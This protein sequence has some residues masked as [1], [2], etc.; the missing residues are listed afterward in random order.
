MPDEPQGEIMSTGESTDVVLV[1]PQTVVPSPPDSMSAEDVEETRRHVAALVGGVRDATGGRRLAVL[2]EVASVGLESQRNAGRQ[3]ELVKTR[4]AT[5]FDAGGGSRDVASD[6]VELRTALDRINPDFERRS[7]WGRTIGALPFMRDNAMIRALRRIAVRY[8]PVSKQIVVIEAKL[9]EGRALLARDNV[10]LRRLYEDVEAQQEAILRQAY[11]GEL[12][13]RE[14]EVLLASTDDQPQRERIQDARHDVLTRVQD[15]R[16]M[17]EVHLQF[18][19]S[20]ELTRQNNTRLGQA[21][22]RTLTMATNIVTVGLAIQAALARQQQVKEAAQRTREFLGEMITQ[23]AAAIRQQTDA[24][25]DLYNDPVIALDK[26]AQA[27]HDLLAALDA[28]SRLRD[29]GI[30]TARQNL[31]ELTRLTSEMAEHVEGIQDQER[32]IGR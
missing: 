32:S 27:H 11:L 21:V 24:I 10:E 14:L 8:E 22:D 9:R 18:F 3:L 25:G 28:A 17:Q 1:G 31:D 13:A 29:D 15:L 23:N 30:Q 4:M 6:L 20:I 19:V 12:L 26:L 5:L 2:D 16:T 7:L